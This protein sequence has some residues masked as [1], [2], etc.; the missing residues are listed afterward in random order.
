MRYNPFR[1]GNVVGPGMFSGR[2]SE[3]QS[4][5]KAVFQT[6]HG[7]PQ[8]FLVTG[9]RGIGKSSL[10]LFLEFLAKG[11]ITYTSAA[12]FQFLVVSIVLDPNSGYSEI[13]EKLGAE[14]QRTVAADSELKELAKAAWEFLSRWEI[15][16]VKY[17]TKESKPAIRAHD[18]LEELAHTVVQLMLKIEGKY[19]GLIFLIDEA[20]KPAATANLGGFIKL[21]TEILT[22]K[23]C[24]NVCLGMAGLPTVLSMLRTGHPS[25][26]RILQVFDLEPLEWADRIEVVRKGLAE[27]NKKSAAEMK[28]TSDA[29][30][31]IA[32][33]SEGYPHFIQ[34]FAYSAF[35]KD[36]DGEIS[37]DDVMDGAFDDGGAFEQLG[38]KY[39]EDL[40]FEKIWSDEYRG[41]LRAIANSTGE[42]V[43]KTEIR[44]KVE[45]KETTL[46]NAL[47]ALIKRHILIPKKGKKGVYR[48][49]SR[50]FGV[51]IKAFARQPMRNVEAG[52]SELGVVPAIKK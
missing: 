2:A 36:S 19:E 39:F 41:V 4:L 52:I 27:S 1:P 29:E 34:Q 43:S 37:I 18:L 50:S 10:F 21:F 47:A 38:V 11:K 7:N 6:K 31:G 8:H 25:S 20:D 12:Q 44:K 42:W 45:L 33:L 22:K 49:P 28:I 35:E 51:W 23:G 5:E 14:L 46:N 17:Q 3:L 16:G 15:F 40:Y 26:T 30:A 48:L 13:V 24:N 9:E 32:S